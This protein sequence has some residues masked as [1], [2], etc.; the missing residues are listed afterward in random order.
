MWPRA[1][2]RICHG[3]AAGAAQAYGALAPP[4]GLLVS[5]GARGSAAVG[6]GV[7]LT[8]RLLVGRGR[9][10]AAMY[11]TGGAGSALLCPGPIPRDASRTQSALTAGG[12]KVEEGRLGQLGRGAGPVRRR[13]HADAGQ[14][15]GPEDAPMQHAAVIAPSTDLEGPSGRRVARGGRTRRDRH[16]GAPT[17]NR[18]L[19][20]APHSAPALQPTSARTSRRSASRS[21]RAASRCA[22]RRSAA[23]CAL[24]ARASAASQRLRSASCVWGGRDGRCGPGMQAELQFVLM[25]AYATCGASRSPAVS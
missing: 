18:G 12:A 16:G 24:P 25:H 5:W 11:S 21:R 10:H 14:H 20:P 17:I 15:L 8:R 13:D 2:V 6:R 22:A 3:S 9:M 4:S 19:P 23:S 7:R 1:A